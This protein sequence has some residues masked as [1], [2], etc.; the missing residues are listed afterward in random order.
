MRRLSGW[1]ASCLSVWIGCT[2]A[3]NPTDGGGWISRKDSRASG[4]SIEVN[5]ESI[6]DKGGVR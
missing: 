6:D 3:N 5:L 2:L 1:S 4:V